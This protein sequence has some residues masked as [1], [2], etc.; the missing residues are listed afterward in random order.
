MWELVHKE[1]WALKKWC[2]RVVVLEKTFQSPVD[3][4]E[5]KPVNPKGNQVWI[6]IGRTE[7]EAKAPILWPPD[8]K[9][10]LT[11][12]DPDAG[13]DWGPEEKGMTEDETVGWHHQLNGHEFEQTA[14]DSKGEGNLM[15][16]SPWSCK[17][18]GTTE[19]LNNFVLQG[20]TCLLF[21]VSL[22]FL[23]LHF[24]PLCWKGYLFLLLVL[25]SLVGLHRTIWHQLLQH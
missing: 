24:N 15:C 21:W 22:D 9:S 25:E 1:N 20:Q 11:G 6:F 5:I 23:L 7:A 8:V 10:Q 16:C 14:G 19:R 2:F 17:E 18:S 13:K 3:C 12:K 4:K